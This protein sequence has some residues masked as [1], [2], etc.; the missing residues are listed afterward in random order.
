MRWENYTP[1]A[2]FCLTARSQLTNPLE[3]FPFQVYNA[4]DAISNARFMRENHP[5][6]GVSPGNF[7]AKRSHR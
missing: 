3:L 1:V 7:V 5:R 6:H 4:L 2:I